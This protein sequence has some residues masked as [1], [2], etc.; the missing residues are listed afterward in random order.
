MGCRYL[1]AKSDLVDASLLE[2]FVTAR[3]R[4]CSEPGC[5][6]VT[7]GHQR[8]DECRSAYE[9]TRGTS[10]Q[11]G[12]GQ[13][14]RTARAAVKPDVEAGNATCWRCG[15]PIAPGATWDMGHDDDDRNVHRGPEH[16]ACNRATKAHALR[17]DET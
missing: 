14:H 5:P 6:N 12:Y 4:V 7:E 16:A 9:R 10:K 3:Y 15:Q 1:D 13:P 11:R 2:P 8:C 17:R